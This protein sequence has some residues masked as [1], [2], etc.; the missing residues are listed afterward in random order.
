MLGLRLGVAAD[1]PVA[2]RL[3]PGVQA[4]LADQLDP[5]GFVGPVHQAR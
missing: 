4:V 2:G 5:A 1:D 3:S